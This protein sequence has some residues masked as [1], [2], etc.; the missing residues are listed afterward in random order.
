MFLIET[1]SVTPEGFMTLTA[2][3]IAFRTIRVRTESYLTDGTLAG[4]IAHAEHIMVIMKRYGGSEIVQFDFNK[5]TAILSNLVS[6]LQN[7]GAVALQA[8]GLTQNVVYLAQCNKNFENKYVL[9]GD[10]A[11]ELANV[12]PMH[13]IRPSVHAH[14]AIFAKLIESAQQFNAAQTTAIGENIDRINQE[15]KVFKMLI[16]NPVAS[17]VPVIA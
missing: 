2:Y 15:I 1:S 5:E 7:K 6:D 14:Y 10:A 9:R 17:P 8:L 4:A 16:S 13:K 11:T 3:A 12:L